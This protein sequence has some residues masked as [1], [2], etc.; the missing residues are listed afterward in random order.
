MATLGKRL[1]T[2]TATKDGGNL[3][4]ASAIANKGHCIV[5]DPVLNPSPIRS[6]PRT[7]PKSS[8]AITNGSGGWEHG[9]G[10]AAATAPLGL[11]APLR[12]DAPHRE[13]KQEPSNGERRRQG[14]RGLWLTG[15][16]AT[17]DKLTAGAP[18]CRCTIA[19][20]SPRA[21]SCAP[22][23]VALPSPRRSGLDPEGGRWGLK[24]GR[25]GVEGGRT[26]PVFNPDTNN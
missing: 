10:A 25:N 24:P 3:N 18:P 6:T 16:K 14:R 12:W 4:C 19:R 7:L 11:V 13:P 23:P 17:E 9:A 15:E 26:G 1:T 8:E 20:P 22:C 2:I 21:A 5:R